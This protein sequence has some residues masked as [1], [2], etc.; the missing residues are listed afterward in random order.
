M[1]LEVRCEGYCCSPASPASCQSREVR[2]GLSWTPK[3]QRALLSNPGTNPN[4]CDVAVSTPSI[5]V[6]RPHVVARATESLVPITIVSHKVRPIQ[7]LPTILPTTR[8]VSIPSSARRR[9][10]THQTAKALL[11]PHLPK[12]LRIIPRDPLPT[13]PTFRFPQP[14]IARLTIGMPLVHH[15]R[16]RERPF[17]PPRE[18]FRIDEGVAARGA[19]EVEGVVGSWTGGEEARVRDGQVVVLCDRS[20]ALVALLGVQLCRR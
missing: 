6:L 5:L 19:E 16:R 18:R 11:M 17:P 14:R 8:A 4:P 12:R 10:P 3:A 13:P 2:T 15:E 1:T 9:E 7:R 20:F